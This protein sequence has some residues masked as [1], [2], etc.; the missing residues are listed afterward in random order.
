MAEAASKVKLEK[1]AEIKRL[2]A[3]L[4]A[5][6]NEISRNGEMLAE[7]HMYKTFLDRLAPPS[8]REHSAA[9]AGRS[10]AEEAH[11]HFSDP[12]QLISLFTELEEQ[13]LSLIQN[14]QETQETLEEMKQSRLAVE[15]KMDKEIKNLSRQIKL[16]QCAVEREEEKANDLEIKAKLHFYGE[17]K[18][19][20]Q[21][22]LLENLDRKVS[23]VYTKCI[24][25][26]DANISTLH[27]LAAIES[28]LEE[29]FVTIESLPVERV[30]AAG[31][32]FTDKFQVHV[33]RVLIIAISP[34]PKRR[35]GG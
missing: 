3:H 5:T 10:Q 13:N 31:K 33:G 32:V 8:S 34:R 2:N 4:I 29:L 1:V 20:D 17:Y 28:R 22:E 9:T 11:F 19:E 7:L 26:N 24:G 6:K 12:A 35:S 27:M 21:D 25:A 18:A 23:E 14:S 16:L 30:E 15:K